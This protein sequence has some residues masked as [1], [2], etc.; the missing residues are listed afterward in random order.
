MAGKLSPEHLASLQQNGDNIRN[1]CILAHV[2]HG[3]TTLSDSLVS[4]NGVISPK[5]AGKLRYLDS[6]EEEQ[7]RGI[8]MHSSAISLIF[9]LEKLGGA[10]TKAASAEDA[11][12]PEEYLINLVDS[13]GHIDFSSDVSTATRLCDG[14]LIVVDVVEGLC[15]QTHAVL[16]KALKERMKP[17]L[18][19]NKIDKL[20][21]ELKLS[22]IEAFHHLRRL[23]ENTNALAFS[24]LTAELR[25][26]FEEQGSSEDERNHPLFEEWLFSP[27]KGNVIFSSA[28]DCW[29]FG[30]GRFATLWAK[31]LEVNRNVLLKYLFEDFSFNPSSK[32]IVKC[33]PYDTNSKPMFVVM[34]LD[35]I[36]QLYDVAVS[37]GDPA[38]AAKM[39]TKL[40]V[41]L[42]TREINPRDPRSSL[43]AIFRRWLPLSDA[44]LRMVVRSMPSPMTAQKARISTLISSSNVAA[45]AHIVARTSCIEKGI[46]TCDASRDADVVIFISK[47][48]P[49]KFNELSSRDQATMRA[50][51]NARQQLASDCGEGIQDLE[52]NAEVFLALGR[53]FAGVLRKESNLYVLGHRH[54]PL[55]ALES[56]DTDIDIDLDND[57]PAG[58]DACVR[59]PVDSFGMYVC[60]GPSVHPVEEVTAGNV[61]AIAGLEDLVL[62][63]ATICSTW[64]CNPLKAITFQAKPIMRVAVEPLNHQDLTKLETGLR[65]LYQYDPAVE[66]GIDELGQQT[67]SCLG[68]LH[69]EQCLK[70]LSQRFAKCEVRASE[71]LVAFRETTVHVSE[72]SSKDTQVSLG[73]TMPA[74]L[75][76][77]WGDLNG[78]SQ[79]RNG[80]YQMVSANGNLSITIRC[81]SVHEEILSLLERNINVM[82]AFAGFIMKR[83]TNL[84]ALARSHTLEES[85]KDN[86]HFLLDAI[87]ECIKMTTDESLSSATE[88]ANMVETCIGLEQIIAVGPSMNMTN[89]LTMRPLLTVNILE[90]AIESAST[91]DAANAE[92]EADNQETAFAFVPQES[93]NDSKNPNIV[94]SISLPSATE[95]Q[96]AA[97]GDMWSRLHGAIVTAFREFSNAGPLMQEQLHGVHF[98]IESISISKAACSTALTRSHEDIH[99]LFGC[100][101]TDTTPPGPSS[102]LSPT[103]SSAA[104]IQG[105]H[106]ISDFIDAL[107]FSMLS[108]GSGRAL[109]VV[110]PIYECDLQ[111]DQSQLGNMYAVLSKRRAEVIKEDII[112]GTNLYVLTATLPVAESF[113]F[114]AELLKKTSGNATAPQLVFSHWRV[115]DLD[116]FWRPTTADELEDYGDGVGLEKNAARICIEKVRKRKGLIV[117]EKIVISAEKQRN[118]NKK[119]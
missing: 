86:D 75:P 82:D 107:K 99:E 71:P 117:D 91:A 32:K 3:K 65:Q 24:L 59:V 115:V 7:K 76:P 81:R 77:P 46:A 101:S 110:E 111:C 35:P 13:P 83:C 72:D 31:K 100:T 66:V 68:E 33:D 48:I 113:G 4:S 78:L 57:V 45:P 1:F 70:S 73:K 90:H 67:M 58:L 15:T 2:D 19:L 96:R 44:V 112:D 51:H 55:Q 10:G 79:A 5:L 49:V 69:L 119:K 103:H 27:E 22:P 92:E 21:L 11:T 93:T 25:S 89:L 108:S 28:V 50:K 104:V 12:R 38:K 63:T 42:P 14:A 23:V 56:S 105:G 41:E 34:I 18:V 36:W 52:Y 116:P 84:D 74:I 106:L 64:A 54:N 8:T 17:C 94:S 16:F 97:L 9:Q 87:H 62:K 61:V 30:L 6:T 20:S 37:Q 85:K 109:R 40:N 114:T 88:Y 80:T 53:V 47:L 118:L 39:A 102:L 43:Q 95:P 26:Q 60:L 98:T 29:G